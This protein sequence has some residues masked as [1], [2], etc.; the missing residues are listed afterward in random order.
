MTYEGRG[1]GAENVEAV[2]KIGLDEGKFIV[3]VAEKIEK[4]GIPCPIR[5]AG[6]TLMCH[7]KT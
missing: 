6:S 7:C 3:D 5:S 2:K 1:R 4:A